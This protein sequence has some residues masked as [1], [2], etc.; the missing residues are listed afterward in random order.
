VDSRDLPFLDR[1]FLQQ[2]DIAIHCSRAQI[3]F[4]VS[5]SGQLQIAHVICRKAGHVLEYFVLGAL[6]WRAASATPSAWIR[7]EFLT[8]ALVIAVALTDEFHQSFVPSRTSALGDVGYDFFGGLVGLLLML[9]LRNEP[10]LYIHIPFCE[11]RCY[12]CAFTVAV[13]PEQTFA[14]Y[15][16]RLFVRLDSPI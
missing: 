4:P 5:V 7:P 13:A 12:Y 11:Q 15:V 1:F 9:R 6:A 8:V 2:R 10:G 14:P 16:D 3:P